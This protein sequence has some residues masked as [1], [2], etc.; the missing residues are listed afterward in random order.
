M[1]PIGLFYEDGGPYTLYECEH[2]SLGWVSNLVYY[3]HQKEMLYSPSIAKIA[4]NGR[5]FNGWQRPEHWWAQFIKASYPSF[6][7]H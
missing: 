6:V 2:M 1:K 7:L 4:L 5:D 3:N